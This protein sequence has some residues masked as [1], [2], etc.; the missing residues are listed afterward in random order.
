MSS[1]YLTA[2][3]GVSS[4]VTG[5]TQ[6][7]GNDGTLQIRTTASGGTATT[8]VTIDNTQKVTFANSIGFGSNAGITFN[9]SSATVNST[10][11]DYET[12]TWTPVVTRSLTAPTVTYSFQVGNYTKV[13]NLVYIFGS[14]SWT[15]NT[16]GTG[17]FSIA[18]LPFTASAG[19]HTYPQIMC[20]DLTSGFSWGTGNT[21]IG[22]EISP[23]TT[24]MQ[25]LASGTG[26]NS[27]NLSFPSVASIYFSGTYQATF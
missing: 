2:D 13:G 12:G 9:N 21:Q 24:T 3:N 20:N 17:T 6:S 14:L 25:I 23:N 7:A 26:V 19:T 18:G 11:N 10:L 8:A 1:N 27:T 4:G 22:V 16:G 5:I 15:A